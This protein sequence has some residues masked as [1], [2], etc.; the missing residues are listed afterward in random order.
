MNII[1]LK[2]IVGLAY[3]LLVFCSCSEEMQL[4]PQNTNNWKVN[5]EFD[6]I[7]EINGSS[8][9]LIAIIDSANTHQIIKQGFCYD[10]LSNP[11]IESSIV[12][13]NLD[14]LQ[15]SVII[16]KLQPEKIYY[17]KPFVSTVYTSFYGSEQSFTTLNGIPIV[18][19]LHINKIT[20][21]SISVSSELIDDLGFSISKM[22]ICYSTDSEPDINSN[23][24]ISDSTQGKFDIQIKDLTYNT[25]YYLRCFAINEQGIGYSQT[26]TIKTSA[27][28]PKVYTENVFNQSNSTSAVHAF[29]VV[30]SDGGMPIKQV[31]FCWNKTGNPTLNDDYMIMTIQNKKYFAGIIENL[32]RNTLYHFRPFATTDYGTAYDDSDTVR[33]Q[34][35]L[36]QHYIA[37]PMNVTSSTAKIYCSISNNGSTILNYGLYYSKNPEAIT[38]DN[39]I[40]FEGSNT[41]AEAI[42]YEITGLEENTLYYVKTYATTQ[43]GTTYSNVKSF[44]TNNLPAQELNFVTVEGG[45]FSMGNNNG[46]ADEAPEHLVQVGSFQI[47]TH[48]VTYNQFLAFVNANPPTD[49]DYWYFLDSG[50]ASVA[51]WFTLDGHGI[52]KFDD[53][54]KYF[55]ASTEYARTPDCAAAFITWYG[56]KAYC[57]WVG[58]RLPTEA[59]WEFAAKGGNLSENYVY[60]GSNNANEVAWN[61]DNSDGYIH[62]VGLMQ[63][64]ELGLFDMTGN[65]EEICSD[66]YDENYYAVSPLIDPQ[67][68]MLENTYIVKRGGSWGNSRATELSN[69]NREKHE[70]Y[71]STKT[72]GFRVVKDL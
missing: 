37:E 55:F 26:T 9:K 51:Y 60:S 48:E 47:S 36:A 61:A 18:D 6:S 16:K 3:L 57:E 69:T 22:G 46:E 25:R 12:E 11:N 53:E 50:S 71:S 10:T 38:N 14:K 59:E 20:Q 13:S 43:F 64:N 44:Y 40:N 66:A 8:A 32:E 68:S 42:N 19:S 17:V 63:P 7:T 72:M 1:K 5:I 27:G 39:A 58:G 67:G 24:I 29:G 41:G 28:L 4:Q 70:K 65:V 34:N 15:L 21:T 2:H 49:R 23:T 30:G 54:K 52:R 35:G 33:T 62:P 56:A 31:G 45:S